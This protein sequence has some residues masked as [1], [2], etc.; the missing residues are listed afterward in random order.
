MAWAL[1]KLWDHDLPL[2]ASLA[3]QSLRTIGETNPQELSVTA[4]AFATLAL[5]PRPLMYAIASAARTRLGDFGLLEIS[6]LAWSFAR[7]LLCDEQLITS[8]AAA[9]RSRIADLGHAPPATHNPN[10]IYSMVWS[11]WRSARPHEARCLVRLAG[12]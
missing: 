2:L 12:Y 11:A 7:L 1:A 6:N 3:S 4:W 5:C 8:I 10:G 9:A